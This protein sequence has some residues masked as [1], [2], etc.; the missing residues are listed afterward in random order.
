MSGFTP[1]QKRIIIWRD[2]ELCCMCGHRAEEANHRINRGMGGRPSLNVLSNGCALC[3][4]CNGRIESD[5]EYAAIARQRGVKLDDGADP[6]AVPY[7]SP[8]Y[9][10]P[11]YPRDDGDLTFDPPGYR[12]NP[13]H[14]KPPAPLQT[15]R[16]NGR[17]GGVDVAQSIARDDGSES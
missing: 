3:H 4:E 7:L 2:G 17:P 8:F 5:A 14:E 13:E 12:V 10:L 9:R 11:V 16:G 1:D 6:R 15:T